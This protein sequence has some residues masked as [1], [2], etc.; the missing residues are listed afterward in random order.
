MKK[1]TSIIIAAAITIALAAFAAFA[2]DNPTAPAGSTC[3]ATCANF[4]DANKDGICDVAATCM[5]DGKCDPSKC[6]PGKCDMSKCMGTQGAQMKC[7]MS[8]CSGMKSAN[9]YNDPAMT[10]RGCDMSKCAGG[11]SAKCSPQQ[12]KSCCPGHK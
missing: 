6:P 11:Q 9:T 3:A 4:T 5:K 7:D 12:A 2:L 8:K 10:V 1:R